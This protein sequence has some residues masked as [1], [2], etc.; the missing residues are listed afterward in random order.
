MI[1]TGR[2]DTVKAVVKIAFILALSQLAYAEGTRGRPPGSLTAQDQVEP[3]WD[4]SIHQVGRL[5]LGVSNSGSFGPAEF[6]K[7]SYKLYLYG[8][9]LVIGAI[10]GQDTIL[11]QG[12][13][14]AAAPNGKILVRSSIDPNLP[15]YD[16][17]AAHHDCTAVYYDTCTDCNYHPLN[18]EITERSRSW[19]Y[20]YAQDLVLF[21]YSMKNIG[22]QRLRQIYVGLYADGDVVSTVP[23]LDPNG[24]RDDMVGLLEYF[25]A[26]YMGENCPVDSDLINIAWT[27]DNDGNMRRP[28]VE[29]HL[30][31]ISGLRFIRAPR[32]SMRVTFNWWSAA[33]RDPYRDFGPQARATYR[34]LSG[35]GMGSPQT[36]EEWYHY[37]SNGERDYDQPFQA[38][39]RPY[40]P[41]WVQPPVEWMDSLFVR[42]RSALPDLNRTVWTGPRSIPAV[43]YGFRGRGK[44]S[45]SRPNPSVPSR[46]S[47]RLVRARLLR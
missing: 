29:V 35:G 24:A 14:P 7:K 17:T 46:Q 15:W 23:G 33:W 31:D 41:V 3:E 30:L 43:H 6:P 4:A 27:A 2:Q 21:D 28:Q 26:K 16:S 9:G 20:E 11:S 47:L 25:P 22:T 45:S 19:A 1:L 37:L 32:D 8:G 10:Q 34:P 13:S 5:L 39:M 36:N 38:L 42:S 18:V 44:F 12:F 40:D